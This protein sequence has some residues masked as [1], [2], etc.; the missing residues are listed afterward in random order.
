MLKLNIVEDGEVGAVPA[1][2]GRLCVETCPTTLQPANVTTQP[3]SGGCVLKHDL[4]RSDIIADRPAAFGRLCVETFCHAV[5]QTLPF[6]AA[7]GRL[8]VETAQPT[9][10]QKSANQPPSGGCV[11]KLWPIRLVV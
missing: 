5:L 11:L 6:P 10:Q 7:F 3:P 2:F 4:S 9:R 1:A 8:C